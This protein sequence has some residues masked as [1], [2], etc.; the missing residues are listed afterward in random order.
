MTMLPPAH[1]RL[2]TVDTDDTVR[3]E[4][5]GE[6]DYETADSL[7]TEV[8]AVLTARPRLHDLHLH[9]AGLDNIDSM[10]LSILLM[11]RR[12]VD[13]AGVRLHLDD[14][15]TT[16][17][18]LLIITG[19]LEYLTTSPTDTANPS[20]GT[21]EDPRTSGEAMTARPTGPDSTT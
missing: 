6:L 20:L 9:C 2:T 18:R 8:T 16:L 17:E 3:I 19:S 10:G 7:L 14:R 15:P 13:Q 5:H 12:R 4:L 21:G 11:I 1:L